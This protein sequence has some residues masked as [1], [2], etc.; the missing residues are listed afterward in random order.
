MSVALFGSAS[1]KEFGHPGKPTWSRAAQSHPS[2]SQ[3]PGD[4]V[5]GQL[6]QLLQG[7]GLAPSCRPGDTAC[8]PRDTVLA[9]Q[10]RPAE[11]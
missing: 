1:P 10:G 9:E 4:A 2:A 3:W 5:P 7:W 6:L 11:G 8:H